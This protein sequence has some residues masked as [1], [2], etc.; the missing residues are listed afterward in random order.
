LHPRNTPWAVLAALALAIPV[1]TSLNSH[2]AASGDFDVSTG[3]DYVHLVAGG[4]WV[5]LLLQFV[6]LLLLVV[7]LLEERAA[8][9][10]GTVRRFSWVAVPTVGLIIATGVI[11]SIDRLG[12]ID[13]LVDTAYGLTLAM[14][15]LLL[16]PILLIAAANLFVFGPRFLDFARKK[17]MA[18]M[19]FRPWEGAFRYALMLEISLAIVLLAATAL[20]TNTPPPG[21]SGGS[22]GSVAQPT[23][24]APTPTADSG[25][26]LV[27]DLSLS[28]WADPAKAGLNDV[29][30]L[31]IDQDGDK[32][33]V[34]KVILRFTFL[35]EDL[36]T[37]E[38]E[39]E[40]L[41]PPTHY[42]ANTSDLSLPG[43]W[44]VEV[45]VRRDGVLDARG[46]VELEISA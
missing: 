45:I 36:G 12:G 43:A 28:V 17:A 7:P 10:A 6:L 25:F 40:P 33:E 46:T 9:L 34:Q 16:A 31:V 13:Q 21:A 5:G 20:L 1:T 15:L 35:G 18:V 23:S 26:A 39:A 8:F 11:Q 32:E 42:V 14:K 29:N 38:A 41:H 3:I 19:E 22:E 37:S 27:D 30:V 44:E 4:V 24:A 2:A